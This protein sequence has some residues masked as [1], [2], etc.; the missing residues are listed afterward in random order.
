VKLSALSIRYPRVLAV[1]LLTAIAWGVVALVMLP[2]Q[3]EPLLTWRL[4]NVVTRLPGASVE[5]VE[6]LITDVLEQRVEE[7]DEVEHIYSVSRAGVSLVQIELS[8]D[9]IVAE[10][11]WQKVRHKLAQAASELPQGVIG[12]DLDDEIMGTFSQLIAVSSD[13]ATYQELKDHAQRLEDRLRYLPATASTTLFGVQREIVQVELDPIKLAAYDLSVGQVAEVLRKRNVR[14]PSGRLQ[15]SE[16]ELLIEASGE[17]QSEEQLREMVLMATPGGR[18]LHLGDVSKIVRTVQEPPEP[19]ARL[20]GTRTVVV[21]VRARQGLRVDRFG[22]RVGRVIEWFRPTLPDDVE[23]TTFH[24]LAGYT[25]QRANQLS[26]TLLLSVTFV[27]LSTALFM[28]WRGASV[29]TATIPVT[30]LIVLILFYAVGIPLNQMSVMAIVMAFGL[31]VDDAIVVTEQIHRRVSGGVTARQAAA[32]EP[33][34][35]FAP[36]VVTTLTTIAAFLPIFLLP[37]GVG[38]FV[39]AIPLGLAICLLTALLVSMTVIPWLCAQLM[40]T[41]PQGILPS[42]GILA[43]AAKVSQSVKDL[44]RSILHR[45]VAR[46]GPTLVL[47][48]VLMS[49]LAAVGLTLR[50]DFFSPVQRDQ[51]VVDVY[52]PDGS[53][54]RHTSELVKRIEAVLAEEEGVSDT[55]AFI[56]RNAPLIFYNLQSQETYANHFAQI[57]VRVAD[58]RLTSRTA[59]RIQTE[60]QSRVAGAECC[61]HILEHGAPFVAPFEIRISGP[62]LATLRELGRRAADQLQRTPGVRNV[63]TNFGSDTLKLVAQVNEPVARQIGLDQTTVADELRYRLDGLAAGHLREDDE[64]IEIAVR[65][66]AAA[67]KDVTDLSSIYFKPRADAPIPFSAAAAVVPTWEASSI[68][69]RDGERTLSVLAYPQFGFTPAEV[70]KRFSPWLATLQQGLPPG[71]G[72]QLGG[73]N[74]QRHEAESHLL[75]NAIYAI[76]PIVLLLMIEFRSLR[77]TVLI[78]AVVPLA[79]GGAMMGLFLTGWPLNFMAMM[80]M[81]MLIGVVVNDALILVDGFQRRRKAGEP[82]TELVVAGTLERSRHVVITT[83]TTIAGFLPLA[84][85]PSL[86]WP[87]LAIVIIGGLFLATLITLVGIPAAYVLLSRQNGQPT[88]I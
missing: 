18:T 30:G 8:D 47:V 87:P 42:R 45:A 41:P 86:L 6:S 71:Y 39:R 60:L 24:D 78:L 76:F 12:P 37:G 61:V 82:I 4:A 58:W 31:L 11:V 66:P 80:G 26:R 32:E 3:E 19:L 50:R 55:A 68:Y 25:R 9:V 29:V 48:V 72:L 88:T 56:G 22:E 69:R 57:I 23:C 63:R 44:Y 73:E 75:G 79:L 59:K 51:F 33:D 34:R 62:S 54:L 81:I 84:L 13:R 10:P 1:L 53:A 28:G 27:F 14:R 40:S 83:V 17:F 70:S 85:S 35:L 46:P 7:V 65:L 15:V 5:R 36:L 52:A 2:R 49:S 20:N 16:K 43:P 74:E 64:R 38:E 77:L 67:R 21:G